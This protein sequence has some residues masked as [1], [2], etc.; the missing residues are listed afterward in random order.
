MNANDLI[1][2]KQQ[3]LSQYVDE[4]FGRMPK[5]MFYEYEKWSEPDMS[6]GGDLMKRFYQD[7]IEHY[8][9]AQH[10]ERIETYKKQLV[11]YVLK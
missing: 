8:T 1:D 10:T 4:E 5:W 3:M 6:N 7:R 2:S 9:N 11:R